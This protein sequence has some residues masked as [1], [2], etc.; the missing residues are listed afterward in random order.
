[1]F[2]KNTKIWPSW[3]PVRR[4]QSSSIQTNGNDEASSHLSQFCG[5]KNA[6]TES[7][8]VGTCQ[9][10]ILQGTRKHWI[11]VWTNLLNMNFKLKNITFLPPPPP[12][13]PKKKKTAAI[14]I[15]YIGTRQEINYRRFCP[16]VPR[17]G[18]WVSGSKA[19]WIPVWVF[20]GNCYFHASARFT[21]E[22][23]KRF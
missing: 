18:T 11:T 21:E 14:S 1:M 8:W 15:M 17:Q 22:E 16:Q 7:S 10:I 9:S 23:E 12:P 13:P 4:E 19:S 3:K 6:Q 2:S 5:P 20:N